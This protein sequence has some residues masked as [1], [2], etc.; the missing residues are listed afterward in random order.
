MPDASTRF[1]LNARTIKISVLLD[2]AEI[3][4]IEVPHGVACVIA[5]VTVAG[6][7]LR[8]DLNAKSLRRAARFIG[9]FGG[10]A[11]TVMLTGRL[12]PGDLVAEAGLSVQPK[13]NRPATP[14]PDGEATEES[15]A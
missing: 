13:A 14:A 2:P 11:V 9:E 5:A 10:Q 8:A 3:G 7:T 12:E 4:A 6:R 1:R 15:H